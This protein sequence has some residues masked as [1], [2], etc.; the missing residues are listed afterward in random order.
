MAVIIGRRRLIN[1]PSGMKVAATAAKPIRCFCEFWSQPWRKI[2]LPIMKR[3]RMAPKYMM[4]MGW[5]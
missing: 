5:L 4:A 3:P 1:R 2:Q